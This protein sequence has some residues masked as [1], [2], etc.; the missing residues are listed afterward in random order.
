MAIPEDER[1]TGIEL[2]SLSS[3]LARTQFALTLTSKLLMPSTDRKRRELIEF[4]VQIADED[5]FTI[6]MLSKFY[7]INLPLLKKYADYWARDMLSCN[8]HLPWS[9]A[10]LE[11][12]EGQW[13]WKKLSKNKS[14]PW[15]ESLLA[16]FED[17][18][19]WEELG[20]NESVPWSESLLERFEESCSFLVLSMYLS[21]TESVLERYEERWDWT[22][23]S[24][25]ECL[26]WTAS[27]VARFEERWNWTFLSGNTCLPWSA[28]LLARFEKRWD[29]S[30]ISRKQSLPWSTEFIRRFVRSWDAY[31]LSRNRHVPSTIMLLLFLEIAEY[32]YLAVLGANDSF[33]WTPTLIEQQKDDSRHRILRGLSENTAFLW[34]ED[35]ISKY[36]EMFDWK[37]LSSNEALPW[38]WSFINKY[39]DR[40]IWDKLSRNEGLPWS[41]SLLTRYEELWDWSNLSGNKVLP[42]SESLLTRYEELW[43]WSRLS[44]NKSLPWNNPLIKRFEEKWDWGCKLENYDWGLRSNSKIIWDE[45]LVIRFHELLTRFDKLGPDRAF[46]PLAANGMWSIALVENIYVNYNKMKDDIYEGTFRELVQPYADDALIEEVMQRIVQARGMPEDQASDLLKL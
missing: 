18:W 41:E 22:I 8:T 23:L 45:E 42:W 38:S 32:F 12:Y 33:P 24:M 34:S 44:L 46:I 30:E 39:K 26:P 36:E 15:S 27:L 1:T 14:L 21:W 31:W 13:D 37:Q 17:R 3:S 16:R 25:N 9:E 28:S 35:F 29:W 6:R 40:W 11:Q 5:N 7:P 43:D 2:S 4:L 19:N 20:L 10:L